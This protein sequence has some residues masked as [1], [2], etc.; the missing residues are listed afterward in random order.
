MNEPELKIFDVFIYKLRWG[1]GYVLRDD[2]SVT[3]REPQAAV[4]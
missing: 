1:R 4:V 3:A 2:G